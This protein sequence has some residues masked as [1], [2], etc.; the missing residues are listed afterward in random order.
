MLLWNWIILYKIKIYE[1]DNKNVMTWFQQQTRDIYQSTDIISNRLCLSKNKIKK[2]T[3]CIN[4]A[5]W[6]NSQSNTWK[7]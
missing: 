5:F 4:C 3:T 1:I 6:E 2:I 7:K